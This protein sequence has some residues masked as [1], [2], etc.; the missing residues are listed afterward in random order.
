[1]RQLALA[2]QLYVSD[3]SNYPLPDDKIPQ[4]KRDYSFWFD[5]LAPYTGNSWNDPLYKCPGYKLRTTSRAELDSAGYPT[6]PFG[7]YG[8]NAGNGA[9][10][11]RWSL[12][13]HRGDMLQSQL[14]ESA[15]ITRDSQVTAPSE[16]IAVGDSNFV[17]W[18]GQFVAGD[19][20]LDYQ[21]GMF[22][23]SLPLRSKCLKLL[24]QRHRGNHNL[25]FCDG[26]IEPIHQS[27]LSENNEAIRR[28]WCYDNDP[29]LEQ[30][31]RR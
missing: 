6:G 25:A 7:S 14:L 16:M 1:V 19:H 3:R 9:V 20:E 11:G 29:H 27:R 12:G 31:Y 10:L 17:P 28:R 30:N 2:L 26:H 24:N 4:G 8:Y 21:L 13:R 15:I 22:P 5:A 18:L 23:D